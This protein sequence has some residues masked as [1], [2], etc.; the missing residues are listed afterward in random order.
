MTPDSKAIVVRT[1]GAFAPVADSAL[2]LFYDKVFELA[3]QVRPMFTSAPAAQR[4]KLAAALT[5]AIGLLDD[6]ARLR[7][8]LSG[9]GQKHARFNLAPEHYA[10]VGEALLWTLA[11]TFGDAFTPEVRSAWTEFYGLVAETMLAGASE[12]RPTAAA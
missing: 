12:P 11:Q 6:E 1:F 7:P 4:A 3:P 10:V 9:L 2:T 5:A 8:V